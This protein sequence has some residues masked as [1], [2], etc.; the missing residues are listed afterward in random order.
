MGAAR[1]FIGAVREE[2]G[3]AFSVSAFSYTPGDPGLFGIDATLDPKKREAAEQLALQIVD[4]V[5]QTGVT[6]DE[7]EKAKKITLG[8]HL[9]ALTTMRGQASDYWFKL[10][11]HA[12][13]EF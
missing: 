10:V 8:Q 13:S 2:A 11:A 4:E 6:A 1:G 3:L 5:K 9:G 7:L 12:R